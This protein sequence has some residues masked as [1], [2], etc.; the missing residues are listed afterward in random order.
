MED[1][2]VIIE[3]INILKSI[4]RAANLATKC[5]IAVTEY[6]NGK[7]LKEYNLPNLCKN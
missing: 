2:K 1:Q 3:V 7:K 6:N 4:G 5:Y